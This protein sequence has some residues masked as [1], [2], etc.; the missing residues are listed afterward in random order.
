MA[1]DCPAQP[2]PFGGTEALEMPDEYLALQQGPPIRISM[3]FG[4][5]AWLVT[6][7]A[8]VRTVLG[9]RRFSRAAS[10]GKDIPR[11]RDREKLANDQPEILLN[12]D[13]PDHTR[14]RQ[15]LAKEFGAAR[16]R[17]L[18][19]RVAE[20]TDLLVTDMAE[21]GPPADLVEAVAFPLSITVICEI[22]GAPAED[23]AKY[24]AWMDVLTQPGPGA[25]REMWLEACANAYVY[26]VELIE[27]ARRTSDPSLLG[28]LV[29]A[30]DEG[31]LSDAELQ[32]L[33]VQLLFNGFRTTVPQIS[34]FMYVLLTHPKQLTQLRTV[35]EPAMWDAA[36]EE[37]WRYIPLMG[38]GYGFV[39][40]LLED[41]E[42][43]GILMRVGD[44]VVISKSAANRDESVFPNA[45]VLDFDR[46]N[47]PNVT[48][49]HG[50]HF[51]PAAPLAR[52]ELDVCV[53]KLLDKFPG[54][55]L[56]VAAE[57]VEW[58]VAPIIQGPVSLPVAW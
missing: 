29:A 43:G 48:F 6:Q 2:F 35:T 9:D 37:L 3:P 41:V 14:L 7:Y 18:R 49:G 54:L 17:T 50:P 15:V 22:L 36:L 26:M 51:C 19:G 30:R 25:P 56:A 57:E 21:Q 46:K 23:Q 12:M 53:R 34:N 4:E 8:H 45:Q 20:I 28:R 27:E 1:L 31:Q 39:R 24:R 44:A 47:V 10:L 32:G 5:D 38:E 52:I 33:G 42:L 13:S 11:M 16:L 55:R 40:Y 58:P